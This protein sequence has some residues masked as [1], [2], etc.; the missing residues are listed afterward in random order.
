LN[1][2]FQSLSHENWIDAGVE[3]SRETAFS[4]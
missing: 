4:Y 3:T 1:V 2:D